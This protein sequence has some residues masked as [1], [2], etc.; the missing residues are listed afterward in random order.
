ME[1]Q[2]VVRKGGMQQDGVLLD[3]SEEVAFSRHWAQ[4][5]AME[6]KRQIPYSLDIA[7]PGP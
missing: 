1:S 6:S 7:F 2:G 4:Y 5:D 3:K